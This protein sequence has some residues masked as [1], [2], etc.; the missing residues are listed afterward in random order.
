MFEGGRLLRLSPQGDILREIRLP[1]RCPTMLAFGGED[2]CTL[3]ITSAQHNRPASELMEYPLSG[4]LLS[5]RVAVP[6]LIEPAY[7]SQP[8]YLSHAA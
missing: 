2:L 4:C 6:G 8:A 5:M 1:L 3:Y 7:L